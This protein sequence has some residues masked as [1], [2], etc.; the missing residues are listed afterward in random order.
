MA[1]KLSVKQFGNKLLVHAANFTGDKVAI[2]DHIVLAIETS[3]FKSYLWKYPEDF[4]FGTGRI[5]TQTATEMFELDCSSFKL[6]EPTKVHAQADYWLVDKKV[7][8]PEIY[9]T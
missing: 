2:I 4:Y 3:T 6:S 8:S 7:K 1:L 5:E 9:L